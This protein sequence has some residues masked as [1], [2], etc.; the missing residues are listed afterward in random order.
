V[1]Y[2]ITAGWDTDLDRS[3]PRELTWKGDKLRLTRGWL[4]SR[5]PT[6]Y[7]TIRSR[8]TPQH[9]EL[10]PLRDGLRATNHLGSRVEFVL[11]KIDDDK[12]VW[13]ENIA[14]GAR[15][16]LRPITII[17]AISKL[18]TIVLEREAQ[19]PSA[20]GGEAP[21]PDYLARQQVRM[22][23]RFNRQFSEDRLNRNMVGEVMRNLTGRGMQPA[24]ELPPRTY[25]A[26]T[27][28]GPEVE[29]GLAGAMEDASFHIT[30]GQW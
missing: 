7:L 13:G 18:R 26:I 11:A 14:E 23:R 19:T 24:L 1:I 25:L 22:Y 21:D 10:L 15:A 12:F 5:T 30:L 16:E 28:V 17:D 6:Q 27:T 9:L 8:K 3:A 20:L 2:P 29:I 4:N